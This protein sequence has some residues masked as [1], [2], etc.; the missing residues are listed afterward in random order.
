MF[1]MFRMRKQISSIVHVTKIK[2]SKSA[3]Q[4]FIAKRVAIMIS[5][6]HVAKIRDIT[7]SK[8]CT[9]LLRVFG[10]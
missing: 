8:K 5:F 10:S 6:F 1:F 7:A 3:V 4:D 2:R 9:Q